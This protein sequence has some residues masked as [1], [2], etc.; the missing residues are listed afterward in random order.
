MKAQQRPLEKL[1]IK[2]KPSTEEGT[3]GRTALTQRKNFLNGFRCRFI[4]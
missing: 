3:K 4:L 2:E 1:S